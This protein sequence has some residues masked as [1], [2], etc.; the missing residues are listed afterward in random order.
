M[1]LIKILTSAFKEDAARRVWFG[2]SVMACVVL[3]TSMLAVIP[4]V[5]AWLAHRAMDKGVEV[6]E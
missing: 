3:C 6:G 5:S 4:A 1:E 2:V